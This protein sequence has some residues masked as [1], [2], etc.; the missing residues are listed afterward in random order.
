[1]GKDKTVQF[2]QS[3][4]LSE[5]TLPRYNDIRNEMENKYFENNLLFKNYKKRKYKKIIYIR[6]S[7][8]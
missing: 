1:M 8:I 3:F 6:G 5:L 2:E 4:F 7:V